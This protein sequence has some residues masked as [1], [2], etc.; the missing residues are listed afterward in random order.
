MG[1]KNNIILKLKSNNAQLLG[2]VDDKN[3]VIFPKR[4]K[5]INSEV[6][7]KIKNNPWVKR[8]IQ[9]GS[10]KVVEPSSIKKM[11]KD[12]EEGEIILNEEV[13]E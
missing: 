3:I 9:N 2:R 11:E 7:E 12:I 13:I 6:W 1:K 8:L 5:T 10:L 4:D